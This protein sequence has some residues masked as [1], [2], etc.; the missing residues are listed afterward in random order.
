MEE[1]KRDRWKRKKGRKRDKEKEKKNKE[2]EKTEERRLVMETYG[3][4]PALR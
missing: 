3:V 2:R 4:G 1:N